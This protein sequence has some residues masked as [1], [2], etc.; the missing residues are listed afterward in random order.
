MSWLQRLVIG[1]DAIGGETLK[2]ESNKNRKVKMKCYYCN[3]K[4]MVNKNRQ[5]CIKCKAKGWIM[6]PLNAL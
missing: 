1:L 2:Y 3:G 4:G 5:C 6:V